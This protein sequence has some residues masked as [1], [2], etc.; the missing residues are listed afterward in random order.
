MKYLI[1]ILFLFL[2]ATCFSQVI[3]GSDGAIHATGSYPPTNQQEAK[4]AVYS[5]QTLAQLFAIPSN[6]RDTGM[7]VNVRDSNA[8]YILIG[9]I[10]NGNWY[11]TA[12]AYPIACS[13]GFNNITGNATDNTSLVAQ[14]AL[15]Q[16][17]LITQNV[18]DVFPR[19][20]N[21]FLNLPRFDSAVWTYA[22]IRK[23]DS[24][25]AGFLTYG[26]TTS[27]VNNHQGAYA[28]FDSFPCIGG[29]YRYNGSTRGTRPP[30]STTGFLI[31]YVAQ[32][33]K[34]SLGSGNIT[35]IVFDFTHNHQY[36]RF[37]NGASWGSWT[38]VDGGGGTLGEIWKASLSNDT[39][40]G[41]ATKY[42][43]PWNMTST[44]GGTFVSKSFGINENGTLSNATLFVS[45]TQ[46]ASG[47]LVATLY[48]NGSATSIVIT[49]PAGGSAASYQDVTHTVTV[50]ALDSYSWQFVNNATIGTA[51]ALI[52]ADITFE[53]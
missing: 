38:Q 6:F 34:I 15:K 25:N 41:G 31:N 33:L 43:Y 20:Y 53:R 12:L 18:L 3:V 48:K 10:T 36:M 46:D 9:G 16:N 8:I 17:T 5:I 52:N 42:A 30:S 39:V 27:I 44:L 24:T 2:I 28:N 14:L 7:M 13:V 50:S 37:Y 11:K 26:D 4:G 22:Q 19:Y 32:D 35:Q 40:P 1:T 51:L 49:I 21:G 47:S 29:W 23:Y 45:G